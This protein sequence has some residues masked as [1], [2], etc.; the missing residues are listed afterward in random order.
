MFF[1]HYR[2]SKSRIDQSTEAILS[3]FR[4]YSFHTSHQSSHLSHNG[5]YYIRKQ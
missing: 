3:V 4:R 2:L 1:Y 5:Q